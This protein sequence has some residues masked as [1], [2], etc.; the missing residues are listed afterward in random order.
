MCSLRTETCFL[1]VLSWS[2]DSGLV[3]GNDRLGAVVQ[4]QFGKNARDVSADRVFADVERGGDVGVAQGSCEELQDLPLS[5]GQSGQG[6]GWL[7]PSGLGSE[8]LHQAAGN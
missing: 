6:W 1:S 3:R 4:V 5:L 2:D 8:V 7:Q